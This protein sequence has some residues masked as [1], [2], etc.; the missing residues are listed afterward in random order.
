M[1]RVLG[2]KTRRTFLCL[3]LRALIF[4]VLTHLGELT[5]DGMLPVTLTNLGGDE[6]VD[7]E[8]RQ[9]P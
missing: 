6:L 2:G 5:A 9:N 4:R 1:A 3:E 7:E 8:M